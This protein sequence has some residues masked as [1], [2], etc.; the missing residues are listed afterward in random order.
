MTSYGLM[1]FSYKEYRRQPF[2]E[3]LP[4]CRTKHLFTNP[5]KKKKKQALSGF[6]TNIFGSKQILKDK[7]IFIY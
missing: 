1:N 3:G 7:Y 6:L 4:R 2:L 5:D